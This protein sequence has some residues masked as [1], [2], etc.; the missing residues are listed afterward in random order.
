MLLYNSIKWSCFYSTATGGSSNQVSVVA[1]GWHGDYRVAKL[2]I[3]ADL[4]SNSYIY[5]YLLGKIPKCCVWLGAEKAAKKAAWEK[6]GAAA[7]HRD[8]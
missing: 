6:N 7:R 8:S 3:N 1:K 5:Q 2:C 4:I